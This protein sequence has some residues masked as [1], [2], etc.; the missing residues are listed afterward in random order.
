MTMMHSWLAVPET[1]RREDEEG[2]PESRRSPSLSTYFHP[3]DIP[4][5]GGEE[6]LTTTPNRAIPSGS[7]H[8][9][10][11]TCTSHLRF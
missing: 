4:C 9:P 8:K 1:M 5:A 2:N 10:G 11:L 6:V 3:S 7:V